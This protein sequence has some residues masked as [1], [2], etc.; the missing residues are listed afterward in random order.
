MDLITIIFIGVC[1]VLGIMLFVLRSKCS[2]LS[3]QL[4]QEKATHTQKLTDMEQQLK[5]EQQQTTSLNERLTETK[6]QL[7]EE[8][9]QTASLKGE[10]T[11]TQQQL[12][13]AEEQR[14]DLSQQNK[15]TRWILYL[16]MVSL[17]GTGVALLEKQKK[18]TDLG[19]K[20]TGLICNY[21]DLHEDIK[22]KATRRLAK[23]AG[24]VILSFVPGLSM[25]PLLSDMGE[26]LETLSDTDDIVENLDRDLGI[27]EDFSIDIPL[28]G[29]P[30]II[31]SNIKDV[32]QQNISMDN[33]DTELK[34]DVLNAFV[35]RSVKDTES[36]IESES[37]KEY[38]DRVAIDDFE[39]FIDELFEYRQTMSTMKENPPPTEEGNLK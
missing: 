26:I 27:S 32:L 12:N 39:E 23:K 33:A 24:E 29:L 7:K 17:Q 18:M 2:D 16:S 37:A 31:Q 9:Q 22:S 36:L 6:E 35:V 28:D 25:I 21:K 8:Q 4:K 10:L 30:S 13:E 15:K 1:I 34:P 14:D 5:G 20:H 19:K 3:N 11:K 38:P